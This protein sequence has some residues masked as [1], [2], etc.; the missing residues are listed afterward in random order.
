M[1]KNLNN[2]F[3]Y[4]G[5][6]LAI[7]L[8]VST[9]SHAQFDVSFGVNGQNTH[10]DNGDST[11][12]WGDLWNMDT[13]SIAQG[14]V[15]IFYGEDW[16]NSTTSLLDVNGMLGMINPRPSPYSGSFQQSI[17]NSGGVGSLPV[18]M[19]D[20]PNN[21]MLTDDLIIRDTLIFIQGKLILNGNDLTIENSSSE[22]IK[23]YT[24]DRYIVTGAGT[25]GGYLIRNDVT[26]TTIN[27]PIGTSTSSYTPASVSNTGTSDHFS[28]RV[29]DGVFADGTTGNDESAQGVGKTW[30]ISENTP[31]GSNLTVGLQH[32][33]S[34]EGGSF[35]QN[36]HFVSH[37]I[38]TSPNTSGDTTS[39]SKWDLVFA[40]NLGAGTSPAT[41]TTGSSI[42]GATLTTRSGFTSDQ[43]FSKSGYNNAAPLPITLLKFEAEWMNDDA[44][45]VWVTAS[46]I[47]NSHFEVERSL[48]NG[49][50][51]T[52]IATVPSR[53]INGSSH[54]LLS[55]KFTD[56][57]VKRSVSK[58]VMYRMIQVDYN[59]TEEVFGPKILEINAPR[60]TASIIAYPNPAQN[61]LFILFD[62]KFKES[63]DVQLLDGYGRIVLSQMWTEGTDNLTF[64]LNGLP[65]GLY[66]VRAIKGDEVRSIKIMVNSGL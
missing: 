40:S 12:V 35:N 52:T 33:T 22:A 27:F 60:L 44:S 65:E 32:N 23:G 42:S 21:V 43:Y 18:M 7:T 13:T 15:L 17:D 47:N 20:N 2:K 5:L 61:E 48:D 49:N 28:V 38:G 29:F 58:T 14:G 34:D 41:I 55:Y 6:C 26:S 62:D 45:L 3:M 46:E 8:F 36:N 24:E 39:L 31:G 57:G 51:F 54:S 11:S 66:I 1:M 37:Y 50:T 53:A 59:S 63:T 56:V 4:I 10:I 19:V 16:V 64:D 30:D 25:T 9:T